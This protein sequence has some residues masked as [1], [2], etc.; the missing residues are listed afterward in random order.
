MNQSVI[1]KVAYFIH[2]VSDSLT[3]FLVAFFLLFAIILN[4]CSYYISYCYPYLP[5]AHHNKRD[6]ITGLQWTFT[7]NSHNST[8]R[9]AILKSC[10]GK[11]TSFKS[12]SNH[13]G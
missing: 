6:P 3:G 13:F 8:Q 12:C 5:I 4:L 7:V 1:L 11:I 10:C 9:C 2:K